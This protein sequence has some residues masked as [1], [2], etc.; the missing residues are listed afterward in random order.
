MDTTTASYDDVSTSDN[1]DEEYWASYELIGIGFNYN[2][3]K[4][5]YVRYSIVVGQ[6]IDPVFTIFWIHISHRY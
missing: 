6:T 5:G 1:A 3:R 4:M 2:E